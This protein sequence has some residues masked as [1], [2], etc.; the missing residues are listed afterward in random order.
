MEITHLKKPS[1]RKC[2][3]YW[4]LK[5]EVQIMLT[6]D[7][8]QEEV[9]YSSAVIKHTVPKEICPCCSYPLLQHLVI[10]E[11]TGFVEAVGKKCRY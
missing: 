1:N 3:F 7:Q 5:K 2:I 6:N 10:K 8:A 11:S 9:F 4:R